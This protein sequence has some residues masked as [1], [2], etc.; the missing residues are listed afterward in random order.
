M[1]FW[2]AHE[3]QMRSTTP[4]LVQ[5]MRHSHAVH[6]MHHHCCHMC[7]RE[8]LTMSEMKTN[9][10]M[11]KTKDTTDEAREC[12]P[13]VPTPPMHNGALAS[14]P[15]ES[16]S[17]ALATARATQST[18]NHALIASPRASPARSWQQMMR[19]RVGIDKTKSWADW[20]EEDEKAV[21]ERGADAG[22]G[23]GAW[24]GPSAVARHV[25]V[26][27]LRRGE[28]SRLGA[29]APARKRPSRPRKR[30]SRPRPSR[31]PCLRSPARPWACYFVAEDCHIT[32]PP[33]VK[34]AAAVAL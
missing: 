13:F 24:A 28:A 1:R 17:R 33:T 10:T 22:P 25:D 12:V 34:M 27:P 29:S 6:A 8:M 23:D 4:L 31:T 14:T 9:A 21:R 3:L 11:K 30:P 19:A 7:S 20:A 5:R 2:L 18:A 15:R 32:R 16:T 26:P